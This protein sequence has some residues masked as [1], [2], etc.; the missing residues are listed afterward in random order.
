MCRA[1]A[2]MH[3]HALSCDGT[4]LV[5]Q[6]SVNALLAVL[7]TQ[8]IWQTH[9]YSL[10]TVINP[11]DTCCH[12]CS[13]CAGF[14]APQ[15]LN[16]MFNG[17][18]PAQQ[19]HHHH[20]GPAAS[21]AAATA[22]AAAA[23]AGRAGTEGSTDTC[24]SS[25]PSRTGGLARNSYDATKADVWACGA[26][27]HYLLLGCLPYG[28]SEFAH[29]VSVRES[30]L[31][32]WQLE[33]T[34]WR[35]SVASKLGRVSPEAQD[36]LDQLLQPDEDARIT[37]AAVRRHPWFTRKLPPMYERALG[38]ME[39]QQAALAA[40]AAA[41]PHDGAAWCAA[42]QQV[43][44]LAGSQA[45]MQRLGA[46]APPEVV[47]DLEFAPALG[48][49]SVSS[50]GGGAS[51]AVS[52]SSSGALGKDVVGVAGG[53][54]GAAALRHMQEVAA[55]LLPEAPP[56]DRAASLGPAASLGRTMSAALGLPAAIGELDVLPEVAASAAAAGAG[57]ALGFDGPA[58]AG[59]HSRGRAA[60]AAAPG[61]NAAGLQATSSSSSG[62]LRGSPSA[63][64]AA[65]AEA[66]QVVE[67]GG[68]SATACANAHVELAAAQG[69][70]GRSLLKSASV[71][72]R[73][74][75]MA[76]EGQGW[77]NAGSTSSFDLPKPQL[78]LVRVSAPAAGPQEAAAESP[79]TPALVTH[80]SDASFDL[81]DSPSLASNVV[82]TAA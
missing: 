2:V 21:A 77:G 14:M 33:Q 19:Q 69:K 1:Y 56:L 8:M 47:L 54:R 79:A 7:P 43:F 63:T 17:A 28:Y 16:S 75:A 42:V 58:A 4:E 41:H 49:D 13:C 45:A 5:N 39:R 50:S 55:R 6:C 22:A 57:G 34:S 26:I 10:T 9:H 11:A 73:T 62:M 35:S 29:L 65:V 46:E 44:A 74:A 31:T 25:P 70:G 53:D 61:S 78:P 27:L 64:A 81:G 40:Q 67:L 18:T 71:P 82:T 23:A 80:R 66:A 12:S 76:T 72:C 37:L 3:M 20:H 60:E 24:V 68:C 30:L 52:R 48:R 36:L 15:V 51:G 59:F 32:L 38:L